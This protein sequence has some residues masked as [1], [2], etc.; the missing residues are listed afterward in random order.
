MTDEG[1]KYIHAL[2]LGLDPAWRRLPASER[3]ADA[4]AFVAV[5]ESFEGITRTYSMIGLEVGADILV[6]RLADSPEALEEAAA[7]LLRTGL[8]RW[9][10]P[11]HS[12]LG[13]IGD[14]QYVARPT[15]QEQTLFEGDPGRYLIVYPFT[16][17]TEW[18]LLSSEVRQGVMNGHI[19][20]GHRYPQVRQLLAYSFGLDDQD[21][22]V[23]Y[24]TDDLPAFGALVRELRGTESRRATVQDTPILAAI[25]RPV[26]EIVDLLG[27]TDEPARTG[28]RDDATSTTAAPAT[29]AMDLAGF[30]LEAGRR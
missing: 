7:A 14:S 26:R 25:R 20:V 24:E 16:K 27:A 22:V 9:L 5:F 13:M 11:R 17:A 2:A 4:A 12:F 1:S 21:F 15:R 6:W 3:A 19:K 30:G 10:T 28:N 23:A 29:S 8:G 18:Y